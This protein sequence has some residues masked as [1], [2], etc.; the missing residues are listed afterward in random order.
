MV[1]VFR[2]R[3]QQVNGRQES[4]PIKA[5]TAIRQVTRAESPPLHLPLGRIAVAPITSKLASV[6]QDLDD[7]REVAMNAGY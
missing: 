3:M 1:G 4:D 2:N 6:Q 7:W 5:A